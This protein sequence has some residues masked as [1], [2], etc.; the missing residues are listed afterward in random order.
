MK[1]LTIL[2]FSKSQCPYC[3]HSKRIWSQ[4]VEL[5][6][7]SGFDALELDTSIPT[8]SALA[9]SL[10]VRTVPTYAIVVGNMYTPSFGDSKTTGTELHRRAQVIKR[11]YKKLWQNRECAETRAGN[12]E[13]KKKE[14]VE[15]LSLFHTRKQQAQL[16][17]LRK[18]DLCRLLFA[19]RTV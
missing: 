3:K 7:M 1:K 15:V 11:S 16:R 18:R 5:L 14:L 12:D 6:E 17:R 2:R 13:W 10:G 9:Q 19:L 4:A 8:N